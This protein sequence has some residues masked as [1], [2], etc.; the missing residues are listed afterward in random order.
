MIVIGVTGHR[1]LSEVE[2][3]KAGIDEALDYIAHRFAGEPI[4]VVS[5]LAEGADRLVALSALSRAGARLRAVLPMP[6]QEYLAD[7]KSSES[8]EEFLSLLARAD[9]VVELSPPA[10]RDEAYEAAGES[11]LSQ[12][13]VLIAVWDGRREQGRGGTGQMVATARSRRMPIAWVKA[14]NRRPGTSEATTL[15]PEQGEV[16]F[17]NL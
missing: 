4:T 3:I 15:G 5:S 10:D 13:D 7:F 1:I 9:E 6:E 14:G 12:S 8:K 11:M 17:E 2:K 16:I